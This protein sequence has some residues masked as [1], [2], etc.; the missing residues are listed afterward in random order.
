MG[1]SIQHIFAELCLCFACASIGS[2]FKKHKILLAKDFAHK[3][4]TKIIFHF[5]DPDPAVQHIIIAAVRDLSG[6]VNLQV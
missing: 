4:G 2:A 1:L 6:K 3:K 5:I